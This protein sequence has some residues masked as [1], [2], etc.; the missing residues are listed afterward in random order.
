[1]T[2]GAPT[3]LT[4]PETITNAPNLVHALEF[5][6]HIV[7]SRCTLHFRAEDPESIELPR[8]AYYQDDSAFSRFIEAR[9]P[10]FDEYVVLLLALAPHAAPAGVE[11]WIRDAL[12]ETD[13]LP[14]IGGVRDKESRALLPTGETA[15]FL[16][17]GDDL[18]RRFEV[19]RIFTADHWFAR[20]RILRLEA[21]REGQPFLSGRLLLEP[22]Y[23]ELF[24]LG[25]ISTP[26]FSASFPA[27]EIRTDL[28][29]SDLVLGPDVREQV[30]ELRRWIEYHPTLL[31][32]WR[33]RRKL[34]PGYRALF[35]GPPGT[36]KTLT[37]T[38]LG[39]HTGRKVFRIDLSSVVSKYVGET[40]KNLANLFDRATSRDWILFF[41]EADA[42]FGKRTGVKDAHDRY[43]NQEISYLLQR[44]EEFDGLVIL[45]SN[46]KANLDDAFLRR[47]NAIIR[48]PFPSE[49]ERAAIW[50][51]C[52]PEHVGFENDVDLPALLARFE[53][54]GGGIINA[55]QHACIEAIGR[56]S[57]VLRLDDALK[58]IRREV[59]KEGKVFTDVVT[60]GDLKRRSRPKLP[61][62]KP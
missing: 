23:I 56:G 15:L 35:H 41:D 24:T 39:N 12:A 6:R 40:E 36:G 55:V 62:A 16:L 57:E 28:E 47:F 45:A 17:A 46:F 5:L 29:W 58:A 43:A 20:D 11:R 22:E 34:R 31:D 60:T 48:F 1:M 9:H 50:R 44:V 8:L 27:R 52:L 14:E 42:L 59:E 32:G 53:L 26:P 21:A 37:A 13:D 54:S 18:D 49:S 30:D 19:Q 25:R 10:S 51:I 33:M 3:E 38:L 7:R 61:P 4:G 2:P